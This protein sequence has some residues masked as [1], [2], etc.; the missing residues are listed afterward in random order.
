ML[1]EEPPEE[2]EPPPK[3]GLPTLL[4][5]WLS[6]LIN[7]DTGPALCNKAKVYY[8]GGVIVCVVPNGRMY[9]SES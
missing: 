1:I 8:V 9:D 7:C 5:R 6:D 4:T 2:E 3:H